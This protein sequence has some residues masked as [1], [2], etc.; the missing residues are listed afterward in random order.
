VAPNQLA[1]LP[2]ARR[3]M[4]GFVMVVVFFAFSA[5]FGYAALNQ[6]DKHVTQMGT[7]LKGYLEAA[8]M[9]APDGQP[10]QTVQQAQTHLNQYMDVYRREHGKLTTTFVISAAFAAIISLFM[11]FIVSRTVRNFIQFMAHS[12]GGSME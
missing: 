6:L 2:I 10:K 11:G 8:A 7:G 12:R 1:N 9:T 4:L 3:I 5:Y